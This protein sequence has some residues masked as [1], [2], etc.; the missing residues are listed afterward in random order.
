MPCLQSPYVAPESAN[1]DLVA[2]LLQA[3]AAR[4]AALEQ[5][6]GPILVALFA[7][8]D[9]LTEMEC[10]V[11]VLQLVSV[12]VELLGD[13]ALPHLGIITSALP[14]VWYPLSCPLLWLIPLSVY[15]P[16]TPLATS[17]GVGI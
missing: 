5:A 15:G 14:Q 11:R 9:R 1:D 3:T 2:E 16:P 8:L 10:M 7:L 12:L 17:H 13:H 4:V 6:A